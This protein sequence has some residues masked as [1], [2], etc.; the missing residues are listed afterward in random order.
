M[1]FHWGTLEV[2]YV[3]LKLVYLNDPHGLNLQEIFS[4]LGKSTEEIQGAKTRSARKE[5][6]FFCQNEQELSGTK[7]L[8]AF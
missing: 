7:S 1:D 5:D 4:H 2:V 6:Q 3:A 8:P